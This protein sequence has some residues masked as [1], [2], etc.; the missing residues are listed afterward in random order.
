MKQILFLSGD[1]AIGGKV[2]NLDLTTLKMQGFKFF[3]NEVSPIYPSNVTSGFLNRNI[4]EDKILKIFSKLIFVYDVAKS[5]SKSK[6]LGIIL[7][8]SILGPYKLKNLHSFKSIVQ[9][10]KKPI[11]MVSI[12]ICICGLLKIPINPIFFAQKKILRKFNFF[13]D[14]LNLL[15]I[16]MVVVFSSGYDNL[17]HLINYHDKINCKFILV[18][19]NWDNPSSKCFMTE[20]FDKLLLWNHQQI[21]HVRK[22]NTISKEKLTVIGSQTAD[23]AHAKYGVNTARKINYSEENQ[24]RLLYIGQ[25]NHYDEINDI[26]KIQNYISTNE[27]KYKRLFYKPHPLSK[28]KIKRIESKSEELKF[29][30]IIR[31]TEIDLRDFD[32]IIVLPTTLILEVVLSKVPAVIYT[33]TNRQFRRDPRTMWKY[34]HFRELKTA[35]VITV[36]QDFSNLIRFLNFGMP[37]QATFDTGMMDFIFPKFS[38]DYLNRLKQVIRNM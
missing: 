2:E 1:S 34:E 27:T 22:L 13:F 9:Q 35:Q 33:P 31:S 21:Q 25:Q 8:T 23:K 28:M 24:K 38:T 36:V 37:E 11:N 6:S 7:S 26:I 17:V 18:I 20:N 16:D 14:Y 12:I 4:C 10:L 5:K 3:Y 19:N 29:V 15:N 32:G 30:S